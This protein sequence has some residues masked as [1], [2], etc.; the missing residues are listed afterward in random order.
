M[1]STA[2]TVVVYY[3]RSGNTKNAAGIIAGKLGCERIEII[4]P[5][6]RRGLFGFLRSGMEAASRKIVPI[7][8]IEQDFSVYSRVILCTP[9]WAKNMSSPMRSF[10]TAQCDKLKRVCCLAT[11]MDPKEDGRLL[12]SDLVEMGLMVDSFAVAP[13]DRLLSSAERFAELIKNLE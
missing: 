11:C 7:A 12:L 3:S 1:E 9:V 10:L 8:P 6:R 2:N 4:N 5:D 13:K